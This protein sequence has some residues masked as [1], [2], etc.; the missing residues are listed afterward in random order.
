MVGRREGV[1][2][3][4]EDLLE[5]IFNARNAG[6]Q[7]QVAFVRDVGGQSILETG[8]SARAS[9]RGTHLKQA[10]ARINEDRGQRAAILAVR[11]FRLC[12]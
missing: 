2:L 10:D 9:T 8:M 12:R 1:S 4:P 7:L 11:D 3:L 5:E 6:G